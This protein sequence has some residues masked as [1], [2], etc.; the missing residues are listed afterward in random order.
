MLINRLGY[1]IPLEKLSEADLRELKNS[2]TVKPHTIEA[3]DFGNIKSFPMYRLSEKK[4]Y[5]PKFFG[6]NKYGPAKS[7]YKNTWDPMKCSFK[8]ELLDHQVDYCNIL[9]NEILINGSCLAHSTTGSG[10]TVMTLW[11]SSKLGLKTLILVH[12]E[13][14][15]NQWSDRIKQFFPDATIGFI[16]Q[17]KCETQN[18]FVIG[19]I[20]TILSRDLP[21]STFDKIGFTIIDESHHIAAASF[22]KTLFKCCTRYYIGLSATPTRKDGLS[23]ILEWSLG[24]IISNEVVSDVGVPTVEIIN[25]EYSTKITPK[26]NFRAQLNAPDLINQLVVDPKRNELI[27]DKILYLHSQN[28]KILILSGRREH[29]INL[30]NLLLSKNALKTGIY[31][32]SMKQEELEKSNLADIIFATYSAVSEA[33]DNKKLDTLIMA[34]GMGDVTQSVG[35]ILRCKNLNHPLVID[36]TDRE[37]FMGQSMRRIAFYKKNNYNIKGHKKEVFIQRV[38]TEEKFMFDNS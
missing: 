29:C 21:T 27:I 2:L 25:A 38:Q 13:F 35:R 14:L 17:D 30:N 4:I 22:S 34:T 16:K 36:I 20:Q 9:L 6:I 28:R 15:A 23:C 18:D 33:Y 24:K 31:M 10:K 1:S 12:K 11:L 19:M 32:G 3:Y 8:G 5:I 37:F 7:Q 26:F